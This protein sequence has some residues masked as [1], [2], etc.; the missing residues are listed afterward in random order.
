MKQSDLFKLNWLDIGKA[1]IVAG[2][3]LGVST[4]AQ[5]LDSGAL[6]T[7]AQLKT[8]GIVALT[9]SLSYLIKNIFT[10]ATTDKK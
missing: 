1:A 8:A 2:I 7:L 9:A 10:P 6:P 5:S 3:T 4:I